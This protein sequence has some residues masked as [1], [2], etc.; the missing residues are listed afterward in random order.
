MATRLLLFLILLVACRSAGNGMPGPLEEAKPTTIE[1]ALEPPLLAALLDW[2]SGSARGLVRRL[3]GPTACQGYKGVNPY[4]YPEPDP[5]VGEEWRCLFT[6]SACPNPPPDPWP[7]W[8]I[9][10]HHPPKASL[11]IDFTPYRMPGCWLLINPDQI[12]Y[13]PE[14]IDGQSLF[15]RDGGRVTLTWIPPQSA[16][17]KRIWF[18][19]LTMSPKGFLASHAIEVTIGN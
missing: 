6:T 10:S 2:E 5:Q 12:I 1:D 15:S 11:P 19:F 8:V 4:I 7:A 16:G 14:Q 13:V 17:G 3:H 18:Q 9:I